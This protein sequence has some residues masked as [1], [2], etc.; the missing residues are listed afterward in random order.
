MSK[1]EANPGT[2]KTAHRVFDIL[3]L[4]RDE[5]GITVSEVADEIGIATSTAHGY[6]TTLEELKYLIR[7]DGTFH[8]GLNFLQ[9]GTAAR[10]NLGYIDIIEPT[11]EN[12]A[13]ETGEAVW[14]VAEE[15]GRGIYLLELEG[16]NAAWTTGKEGMEAPLHATAAGK[17]I[18][19]GQPDDRIDK[20]D[21]TKYTETTIT[22][23]DVLREEIKQVR[24]TGV[25]H[26]DNEKLSGL[27]AV[28][29]PI[30]V[31]E[32]II[33][34]ISIGGPTQRIRGDKFHEE[35]PVFLRGAANEIE[36]NLSSSN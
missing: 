27:R 25:A 21:L 4:V 7:E 1:Q 16:S 35:L 18:L 10:Q 8:V 9:Y 36:L 32:R 11:L 23:R 6:L 28:A 19:S 15:C 2:I 13:E 26:N 14:Y 29:C 3:E 34:A 24:E 33:G 31:E 20:I 22:D 12:V 5:D 17:A 30:S